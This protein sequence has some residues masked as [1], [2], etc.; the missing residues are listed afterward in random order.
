MKNLS[1][2]RPAKTEPRVEPETASR[3]YWIVAGAFA[4]VWIWLYE[5]YRPSLAGPFLFDDLYLPFQ[6]PGFIDKPL[7][8][9]IA[10]V[11]PIL[12]FT[13]WL[14]VRLWGLDPYYF[15]VVNLVLHFIT[16]ILVFLI[17][18]KFLEFAGERGAKSLWLAAVAGVVFLIHPIQTESVAYIASRSE[19]FSVLLLWA[20]YVLFLFRGPQPVSFPRALAILAVLGAAVLTKEHTAVLPG[21]FLLTDYFWN[22]GFSF[23]GIKK[24][25]RLYIP[26]ALGGVAGGALIWKVLTGGESAGFAMKD[27]PWHHYFLTQCRALWVYLRMLVWPAGQNIDHDFPISRTL[28]D[29]GAVFGMVG[30]IALV[31]LAWVYRKRYP[32]AAFGL[33]IA[34][35]LF[36]PT[37]SFAPI[38]DTLVERRLYLPLPGLLLV[39]LE[40]IRRWKVQPVVLTGTLLLVLAVLSAAT[41]KRNQVWSSAV[42][43]WED[44]VAGAPAKA[45]PR[46]QLAH[47]HYREGRCAEAAT[48]YARAA[49]LGNPDH[50][51]F[52]DWALALDCAG[53]PDEALEKLNQAA[54]L[55]RTAHVL[56]TIGMIRAK[57]GDREQALTV[58]S[59][60][61]SR[62]ANFE[63]AYA[64]RGNVYY[65]LGQTGN[66][67]TDYEKALSLNP[68]NAVASQGIKLVTPHP[69]SAK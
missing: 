31:V 64:Y 41:W 34:L 3:R 26:I 5:T 24:N 39:A 57:K 45:R 40:F 63:M 22:P 28:I 27:L 67:R 7:T 44:A 33:F 54:A 37:S 60:A 11:R 53:R 58:L 13:F 65:S 50:S 55:E 14:N 48:H 4:V 49:E 20:A 35:I 12:M 66:A 18:R 10:G 30:L 61:I 38:R 8:E 52:V 21:V 19:T 69:G 32:L 25:L 43:V 2:R 68:A 42:A 51:L 23:Q 9:W 56:S 47:A 17:T 62:D 46:F 16:G 15:H 36:A 59:E 1:R 29:H 6:I